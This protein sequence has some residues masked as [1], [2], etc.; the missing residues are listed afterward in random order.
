MT[1]TTTAYTQSQRAATINAIF[2][3][4]QHVFPSCIRSGVARLHTNGRNSGSTTITRDVVSA[5]QSVRFDQNG[6]S[7][8][9]LCSCEIQEMVRDVASSYVSNLKHF[10]S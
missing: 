2:K 5:V 6:D 8:W 10:Q 7:A 3:L 4:L 9:K 1:D